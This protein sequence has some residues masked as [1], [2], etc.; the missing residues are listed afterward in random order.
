MIAFAHGAGP[1]QRSWN[2]TL[3]AHFLAAGLATLSCDKR[4]IGQS[5]GDYPGEGAVQ[6]NI[7]QYARDVEAQARFLAT[8]SEIDPARI[9]VAG[10][11]QAGWIMPLAAR[12]EPAIRFMVGFVAPTLTVEQTD[13]WARLT[14]HGSQAPTR[15]DEEL[16][17]ETRS[18]PAAG[19]D[20]L[21]DIRALRIPALWLLGGEDRTVPSRLCVERLE[22]VAQEPGR[23]FTYRVFAGGTHGLIL[24]ANGLQ[25]EAA[26]SNRLVTGLHA[27]I[28]GWLGARSLTGSAAA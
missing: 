23:D 26:A 12:R 14:D 17:N 20:P 25:D 5:G 16:E 8:Q 27:T 7:D 15:S 19:F 6:P 11:S 21:P 4:G 13:Y 28:R 2:S 24:T 9:G 10:A 3:G 1:A 18:S 22:P